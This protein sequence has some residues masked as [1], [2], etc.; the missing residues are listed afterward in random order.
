MAKVKNH[1]QIN[2]AVSQSEERDK[3]L[4]SNEK[5][6]CIKYKVQYYMILCSLFQLFSASLRELHY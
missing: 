2:F 1:P 6:V 5:N 4:F 3:I